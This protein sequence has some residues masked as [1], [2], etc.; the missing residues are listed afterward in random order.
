MFAL[1]R[2]HKGTRDVLE[3][4]RTFPCER[5][6]TLGNSLFSFS[7]TGNNKHHPLLLLL[8]LF[9]RSIRAAWLFFPLFSSS[10][11]P[12]TGSIRILFVVYF[13]N[14]FLFLP[15]C[16]CF[17]SR[18]RDF[19]FSYFWRHSIRETEWRTQ[20]CHFRLVLRG[21]S[22]V[23]NIFWGFTQFVGNDSPSPHFG[24]IHRNCEVRMEFWKFIRHH[25]TTKCWLNDLWW[26]ETT[27]CFS[28]APKTNKNSITA[29]KEQQLI[30]LKSDLSDLGW[31]PH[32]SQ[33]FVSRWRG[34][35]DS[36]PSAVPPTLTASWRERGGHGI[37]IITI[38]TRCAS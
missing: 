19:C 3:V 38:I 33:V 31:L 26:G 6:D 8:L 35:V 18:L 27:Q 12:P 21:R 25:S 37:T 29:N 24:L 22:R 1:A 15:G 4:R 2:V 9:L 23:T 5:E 10:K 7:Y 34:T 17:L 16:V 14:V 32:A 30:F 13:L 28:A 20:C 11:H 36:R